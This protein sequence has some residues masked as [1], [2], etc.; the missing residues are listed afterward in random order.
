MSERVSVIN[1]FQQALILVNK[2]LDIYLI[3]I[4]L[5]LINF[6]NQ[7][8]LPSSVQGVLSLL[9]LVL[10]FINLGFF[11]SIPVFL[12]W[13]RENKFTYRVLFDTVL[14]NTRRIIVP[15]ILF[16][17]I[18][19]II[20]IILL[21]TYAVTTVEPGTQVQP[22]DIEKAT[23]FLSSWSP[24]IIIISVLF[25]IIS[26]LFIFTPIYFSVEGNGF[27][28]SI[29]K[30]LSFSSKHLD[31]IFAIILVGLG[32]SFI[33][34]LL[35]IQ[36]LWGLLLSLVVSQYIG[37]I[38]IAAALLFYKNQNQSISSASNN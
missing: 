5:I 22:L 35:P 32:T 18:S 27:F 29:I 23:N 14:K 4:S 33:L 7:L 8:S 24:V 36:E 16:L 15:G 1:Y 37:L 9:N 6:L 31:F 19:T 28:K 21:I 12:L 3:G 11:L 34:R 38:M 10:F 2:N 13:K 25:S 20:G 30:S 26:S 17:V